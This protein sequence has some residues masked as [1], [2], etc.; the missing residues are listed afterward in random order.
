M[1]IGLF[2]Q[3]SYLFVL[4][5]EHFR[6]SLHFEELSLEMVDFLGELVRDEV[7]IYDLT[8]VISTQFGGCIGVRGDDVAELSLRSD[9]VYLLASQL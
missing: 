5:I 3:S 7:F 4:L 9:S 6:E 1:G 8:H 2:A